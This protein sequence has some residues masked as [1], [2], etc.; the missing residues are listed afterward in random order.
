MRAM[1]AWTIAIL[2]SLAACSHDSP[3]AG[4]GAG[5]GGGGGGGGGDEGSDAAA[6]TALRFAV[7]GDTGTG[8]PGQA[9]VAEAVRATCERDG[10]DFVLLLGDN[11]YEDGA[12]SVTDPVWQDL[13]ETPYASIDLPFYAVLG[14]H[15]YG[16]TL[17]GFHQ[18]GLGNEFD[19]GPVEV[20]YS[21]VSTKWIMPDTHYVLR[22]GPVGIVA[23]DTNSIM[24]GNEDNGD[25]TPWWPTALAEASDEATW[26]LAA[27]HHP[28]LS[29][30]AHGNAG[31]YGM[32]EG[33][34]IVV[35]I[36]E[37]DGDKVRDF[38]DDNV[39][40]NVDVYL[41]GHDHNRQWIDAPDAC[42]GTELLVNGASGKFKPFAD[43]ERN[44]TLWQDDATEGFLHVVIDGDTFT[45]RFIDKDGTVAFE[46]TLTK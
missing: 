3:G 46:N 25:Q 7:L 40:G 9:E 37:I 22:F 41:S 17:L 24:W 38:F 16:G 34:D 23:L 27:G 4:D 39:C 13:F 15:D 33:L 2:L 11:L 36:D 6:P 35:P 19:R 45:G 8:T 21:A 1:R 5:D 44:P 28:Y 20:Q 31:D 18:A 43:A 12:D 29:N 30:G 26:V 32:I 14:N 10:C 42:G